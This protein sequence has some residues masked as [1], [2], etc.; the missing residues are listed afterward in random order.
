VNSVVI[1]ASRSGNT[2]T[3]AQAIADAL[4]SRG[5]AQLLSVDEA[6]AVLPGGTDL[7]VIGGPTEGHGMNPP[8]RAF[9][10]RIEPSALDGIAAA[11]FDT[12]L[13]WPRLLSG[14]A[15]A[16]IT[17]RLRQ[18]GARVI[19]PEGSFI[20]TREPRLEPGELER[21]AAWATSLADTVETNAPAV[22][23]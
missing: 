22:S 18:L 5:T 13:G 10:D 2:H 14:S 1:F 23:V 7:V 12:R 16:D 6:P 15:A 4:R 11:A 17:E 20:V 8:V 19:A 9:L 21:A 3:V